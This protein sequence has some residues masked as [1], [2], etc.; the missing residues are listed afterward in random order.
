MS[1]LPT[2]T[3]CDVI[4]CSYRSDIWCYHPNHGR[5]GHPV[6]PLESHGIPSWCPLPDAPE[7]TEDKEKT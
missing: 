6:C 5:W 7:P 4:R 1:D 2:M 3:K